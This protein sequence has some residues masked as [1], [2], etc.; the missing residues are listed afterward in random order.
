[1]HTE[2][3][4]KSASIAPPGHRHCRMVSK[5]AQSSD[6]AALQGGEWSGPTVTAR[7]EAYGAGVHALRAL[8]ESER[9]AA[10]G[11]GSRHCSGKAILIIDAMS[12]A[13]KARYVAQAMAR[14]RRGSELASPDSA[15]STLVPTTADPE[16]TIIN[17]L[18]NTIILLS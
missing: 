1:M 8:K 12:S 9:A 16:G 7:A 4:I 3:V 11:S 13:Y 6:F 18:Y 14:R 15:T 2:T 17:A 10:S 5:I